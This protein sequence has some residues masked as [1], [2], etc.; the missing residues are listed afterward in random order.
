ML[1]CTSPIA[2]MASHHQKMEKAFR[3][4]VREGLITDV[5]SA[6]KVHPEM[7]ER[8]HNYMTYALGVNWDDIRERLSRPP[9]VASS[10]ADAAHGNGPHGDTAHG[11][12]PHADSGG[13]GEHQV[14]VELLPLHCTTYGMLS[15]D[16]MLAAFKHVG[17]DYVH[18]ALQPNSTTTQ[19]EACLQ[20]FEFIF[21][22]NPGEPIADYLHGPGQWAQFLW[23]LDVERGHLA[24]NVKPP[25]CWNWDGIYALTRASG[26][27]DF[28]LPPPGHDHLSAA[29]YSA[30]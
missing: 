30:V 17:Y 8:V 20:M 3:K 25:V 24:R 4:H 9:T 22:K 2:I 26:N 27:Q 15:V 10:T 13:D 23:V 5:R 7:A 21:G 18:L 19:K 29:K 12:G 6:L 1:L 14:D 16:Q 11:N 28:I